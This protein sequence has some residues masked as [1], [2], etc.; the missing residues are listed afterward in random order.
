LLVLLT[1]FESLPWSHADQLTMSLMVSLLGVYDK[2]MPTAA[3]SGAKLARMVAKDN[4]AS[5]VM[6]FNTPY[7]DTG[8]F[9]VYCVADPY[10]LPELTWQVQEEITRLCFEV[11]EDDLKRAVNQVGFFVIFS[12]IIF[13]C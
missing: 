10:N 3:D 11:D 12:S 1:A 4:L 13:F 8:L 2:G 6:P 5:T 9:G 7:N